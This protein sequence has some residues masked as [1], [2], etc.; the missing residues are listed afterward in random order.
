M[1][2]HAFL[3]GHKDFFTSYV[4]VNQN[5]E[6]LGYAACWVMVNKGYC[7]IQKEA[8]REELCNCSK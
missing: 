4:K 1:S 2:F 5:L 8:E 6:L 7:N 3:T